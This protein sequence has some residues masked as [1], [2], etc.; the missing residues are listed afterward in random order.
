VI[1]DRVADVEPHNYPLCRVEFE[2]P[3]DVQGESG[4]GD[5]DGRAERQEYLSAN[6]VRGADG[7]NAE[8]LNIVFGVDKSGPHFAKH[9]ESVEAQA[10]LYSELALKPAKVNETGGREVIQ[11]AF[12]R[13][14]SRQIKCQPASASDTR[15]VAVGSS[16]YYGKL[17]AH[18]KLRFLLLGNDRLMWD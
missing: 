5:C 11:L 14:V 13:Q 1:D 6:A 12:E 8:R 16:S 2:D 18:F 3:A 17:G 15:R 9:T 10:A 7:L 4:V